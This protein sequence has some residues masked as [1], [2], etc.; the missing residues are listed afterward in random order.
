MNKIVNKFM[1]ELL[2]NSQDLI[3]TLVDY[4]LHIVK[5]FKNLE[6]QVI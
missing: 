5:E 2:Q 4:L 1:S 3:I 6:N